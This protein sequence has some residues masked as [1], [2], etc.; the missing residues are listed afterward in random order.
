[1]PRLPYASFTPMLAPPMVRTP[2]QNPL[3]RKTA[4]APAKDFGYSPQWLETSPGAR[5]LELQRRTYPSGSR[6]SPLPYAE[7]RTASAFSFLDGASLPEDLVARAAALDLPAVALIDRNGVYGAP[8]F[9]KAAREAGIKALVGAEITLQ[10][11]EPPD[12]RRQQQPRGATRF[13]GNRPLGSREPD[14][15]D[16]GGASSFDR[17]SSETRLTLL[18]ANRQGYRN[19]CRLLTTATYGRPKGEAAAS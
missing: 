8:R 3:D 10:S 19:L 12:L 15:R 18:V 16:T 11:P 7:L 9:Y 5:K 1:M 6:C 17:E 13:P 2:P 14:S 4:G